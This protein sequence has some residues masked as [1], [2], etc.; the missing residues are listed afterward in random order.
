MG[1]E[2]DRLMQNYGVSS[3]YASGGMVKTHYAEGDLVDLANRYGESDLPSMDGMQLAA[4]DVVVNPYHFDSAP[5]PKAT[6]RGTATPVAAPIIAAPIAST[7]NVQAPSARQM[8]S[9]LMGMLSRY[10]GESPYSSELKTAREQASKESDAFQKMLLKAMNEPADNA[11]SKAEMYFRL[12]SAFGAPT[13]TGGFAE[14]LGEVG[15]VLG[16]H[17]KT[18]REA[19]QAA[20]SQKLQLG[21]EGQKLKM[22]GAKEDLANLRGLASEEMKDKRTIATELLKEYVKSG[23]PSSTAGKQAQDEGLTPGTPAFQKRVAQIADT[24]IEKQMAGINSALA[25]ISVAQANQALQQN[26]F[27]FQQEQSKKLT[28]GEMKLKTDTEDVL[29]A[30]DV[31]LNNL[32]QAYSLNPNTFDSSLVDLAQ[33]KLLEAGGSKDPKVIATRTM[34]NLLQEKALAGLKTAFG[35]NPTEG[36]RKIMLDIQGIG[37]K[38]KEE[39]SVILKNAYKAAQEARTRHQK[40][41]NEINQGLYRETTPSAGGIE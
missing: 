29:G 34:E 17:A 2:L 35:G 20:K 22:Q 1:Y 12:A 4:N 6:A 14:N 7:T 37:A 26:K 16:E 38:S 23:Q 39:R 27:G 5:A 30:S 28:P 32:K 36:E 11:P 25:G 15:K 33:R 21:I 9:D 31:A 10:Q 24:N 8:P 18:T 13:K 40:R 19:A 3:A 41:L